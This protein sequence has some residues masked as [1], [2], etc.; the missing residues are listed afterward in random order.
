MDGKGELSTKSKILTSKSTQVWVDFFISIKRKQP[1]CEVF[2]NLEFR[3]LVIPPSS[4]TFAIP[5]I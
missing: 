3:I 4:H 2:Q 1:F 5:K